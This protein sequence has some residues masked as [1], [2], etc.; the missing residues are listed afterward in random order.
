M[1]II[2]NDEQFN[3]AF[4][5]TFIYSYHYPVTRTETLMEIH[6]SNLFC[7]KGIRCVWFIILNEQYLGRQMKCLHF[8]E[9]LV[10]KIDKKNIN[11]FIAAWDFKWNYSENWQN[12]F[13]H[14]VA[15]RGPESS[16]NWS[17]NSLIFILKKTLIR[18]T[19]LALQNPTNIH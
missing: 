8:H 13:K 18:G 17:K 2:R 12:V 1:H 16:E 5:Q 7:S 4:T 3:F 11:F 14:S 10:L 9:R 15:L 19:Y 6:C